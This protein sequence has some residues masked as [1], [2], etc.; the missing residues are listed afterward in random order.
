MRHLAGT[1]LALLV[2]FG[3]MVSDVNAEPKSKQTP[4][5]DFSYAHFKGGLEDIASD[6]PRIFS[7]GIP[8]FEKDGVEIVKNKIVKNGRA[9]VIMP[10]VLALQHVV[11]VPHVIQETFNLPFG[12][13]TIRLTAKEIRAEEH[14]LQASLDSQDKIL[15]KTVLVLPELDIVLFRID[16]HQPFMFP[17]LV[18]GES[19]RIKLGNILFIL[20]SPNLIGPV[21]RPGIVAAFGK[22]IDRSV[23]DAYASWDPKDRFLI[24]A[25]VSSGDSGSPI[26]ALRH[27]V[28][29]VIGIADALLVT[30]GITSAISVDLIFQAIKEKSGV[31]L[32]EQAKA[33]QKLNNREKIHK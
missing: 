14:Y 24:S 6:W 17:Q 20:G 15:L 18:F 16:G 21:V 4:T 28:P 12:K 22:D 23:L 3:G 8:V 9:I 5:Y 7:S 31:D 1:G 33:N 25:P 10:Y 19:S 2:F 30:S 27:G 29:E 26:V 13:V 32:R 11:N